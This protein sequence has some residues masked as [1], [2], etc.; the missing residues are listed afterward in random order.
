MKLWKY[1]H[2]KNKDYELLFVWKDSDTLEDFVIYKALYTSKEFWN[3]AIWV[4]S[5]KEFCTTLIVDNKEIERF[6]YI[7]N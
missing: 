6:K 1:R 7:W 5:L 4:K 3:N 2:Y